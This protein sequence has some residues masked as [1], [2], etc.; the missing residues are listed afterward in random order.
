MSV[1]ADLTVGNHE[2]IKK[3]VSGSKDVSV[4]FIALDDTVV[5]VQLRPSRENDPQWWYRVI[6]DKDHHF[7]VYPARSVV[8]AGEAKQFAAVAYSEGLGELIFLK[9]V[10]NAI[11]G[12]FGYRR[13]EINSLHIR[14]VSVVG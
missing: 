8:V 1:S 13:V 5:R 2:T 14:E 10:H 9:R 3:P 12:K 11:T 4:D 6:A 7:V